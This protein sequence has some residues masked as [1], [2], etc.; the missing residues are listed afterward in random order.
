MGADILE[1]QD[2]RLVGLPTPY[3]LDGRVSTHSH[4][5]RGFSP[6]N[7]YVLVER[8]AAL[9]L[10]AGLSAHETSLL[11]RLAVVLEGRSDVA[12]FP[13]SLG[14]FRSVSN[15]RAIIER[16][17]VRTLYG[18]RPDALSWIDFRGRRQARWSVPEVRTVRDT[19]GEDVEVGARRVRTVEAA[20][21]APPT[22]WLYDDTTR[23]LFT[24][25]AFTHVRRASEAGP[26]IVDEDGDT[27]TLDEVTAHL[28]HGRFWWVRGA[29][30]AP[31]RRALAAVFE[32]CDVEV[33][34]PSYGCILRGRAVV[35]RHHG[36][37]QQALRRLGRR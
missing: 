14:E 22:L 4:D 32:R 36:L 20:L 28:E 11:R 27:T 12:L 35:E 37:L 6:M 15:A 30:V 16:F 18:L 29:H 34:A 1:L 9:V 5:V 24:A 33:V 7:T 31:L 8:D 2:G 13:L 25:D 21:R 3:R 19:G 23:T 10:E 26:W 17:G